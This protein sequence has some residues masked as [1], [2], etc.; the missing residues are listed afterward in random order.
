M[1]SIYG[2]FLLAIEVR[3]I[4]FWNR[5]RRVLCRRASINLPRIL[6]S[7]FT[8]ATGMEK[9]ERFFGVEGEHHER[10]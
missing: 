10:C 2:S 5:M 1:K 8:Y 3:L 7:S 4:L 9:R 6:G